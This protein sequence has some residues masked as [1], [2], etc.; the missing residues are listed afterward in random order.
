MPRN[1]NT[2]YGAVTFELLA[3]YTEWGTDTVDDIARIKKEHANA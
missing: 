2:S 3:S 1:W